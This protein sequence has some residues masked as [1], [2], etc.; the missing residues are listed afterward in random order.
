MLT[1]KNP[2]T[3]DQCPDYSFFS[4]ECSNTIDALLDYM[5]EATGM[6]GGRLSLEHDGAIWQVST[7]AD[8]RLSPVE[9][10]VSLEKVFTEP[11]DRFYLLRDGL[12]VRTVTEDGNSI[13]HTAISVNEKEV[14]F[15]IIERIVSEDLAHKNQA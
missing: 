6:L 15:S 2:R 11:R 3:I 12:N 14:V 9:D 5:G 4:P 13:P 10:F 7:Y 1:P 8:R